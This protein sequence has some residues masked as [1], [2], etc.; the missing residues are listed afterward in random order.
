MIDS[1]LGLMA[2]GACISLRACVAQ[3]LKL[4]VNGLAFS[5]AL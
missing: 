2:K 3:V 4:L 1:G 5:I